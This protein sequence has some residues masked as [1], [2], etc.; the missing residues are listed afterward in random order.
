MGPTFLKVV[1]RGNAHHMGSSPRLSGEQ[2]D[3]LLSVCQLGGEQV[4]QA[5]P[6]LF[7]E[8]AHVPCHGKRCVSGSYAV[9][10]LHIPVSKQLSKG[11]F[12]VFLFCSEKWM[13]GSR[14]GYSVSQ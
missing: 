10:F 2:Q 7:L 9:C 3:S 4:A 12:L 11:F 14:H 8:N 1:P 13:M 5:V 6:K